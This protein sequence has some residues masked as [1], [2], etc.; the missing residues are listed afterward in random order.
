MEE[1]LSGKVG[2]W[3]GG[4]ERGSDVVARK[5]GRDRSGAQGHGVAP[6]PNTRIDFD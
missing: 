6:A 4:P 3:R 1:Y 2:G 5:P